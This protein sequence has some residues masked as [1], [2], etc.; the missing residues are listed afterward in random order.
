MTHRDG[1]PEVAECARQTRHPRSLGT[2]L[3]YFFVIP[4]AAFAFSLSGCGDSPTAPRTSPG[5]ITKPP[6]VLVPPGGTSDLIEGQQGPADPPMVRP[7]GNEI[8]GGG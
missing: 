1:V 4:L 6:A 2:R 7:T 3:R 5:R 8:G